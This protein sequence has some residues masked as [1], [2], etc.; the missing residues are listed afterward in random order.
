MEE[1]QKNG[2][3]TMQEFLNRA[4]QY[5]KLETAEENLGKSSPDS[6][7]NG[8]K[9]E[10][11]SNKNGASSSKEKKNKRPQESTSNDSKRPK[12][13]KYEPKFTN[14]TTLVSTR[15]EVL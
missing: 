11:D 12:Y 1:S 7:N 5:I 2:V 3:R 15:A 13:L 10:K 14:Y 6:K 4:D 9:K 8:S